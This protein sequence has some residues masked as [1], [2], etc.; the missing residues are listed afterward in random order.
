MMPDK[1]T[2]EK[3]LIDA[4][5]EIKEYIDQTNLNFIEACPCT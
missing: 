5:F 2:L 3:I 1:D 4:R